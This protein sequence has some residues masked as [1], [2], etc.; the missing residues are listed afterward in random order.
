[1]GQYEI[2]D[3]KGVIH[4]GSEDEMDLAYDVLTNPE[5][6]GEELRKKYCVEWQGDLVLL[7]VIRTS[8]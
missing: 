8:R 2:R 3:D 5:A 7:K 6:Y 1:M 4:S